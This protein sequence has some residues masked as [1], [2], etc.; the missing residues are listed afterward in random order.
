VYENFI[1]Y[2]LNR[3]TPIMA[4]TDMCNRKFETSLMKGICYKGNCIVFGKYALQAHEPRGS[5]LNK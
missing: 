5:H 1:S 2:G 4:I 3:N